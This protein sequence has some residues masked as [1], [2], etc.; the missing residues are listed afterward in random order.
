MV[1]ARGGG[2]ESGSYC[3]TGIEFQCYKSSVSDGNDGYITV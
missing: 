3:L 2:G 1:F